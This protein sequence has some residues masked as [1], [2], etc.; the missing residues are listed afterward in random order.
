MK[1]VIFIV[2]L[3]AIFLSC[4][5]QSEKKYCYDCYK[6]VNPDKECLTP[7]CWIISDST[8]ID[9]ECLRTYNAPEYI[10]AS[11]RKCLFTGEEDMEK[12]E[13]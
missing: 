3:L 4:E 1:K 2:V 10:S 7:N 11:K 13:W 8:V 6:A 12:F 5:K 9:R